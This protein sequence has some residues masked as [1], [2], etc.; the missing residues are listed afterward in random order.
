[1]QRGIEREHVH[2]EPRA[3]T[4][5]EIKLERKVGDRIGRVCIMSKELDFYLAGCWGTS[6]RF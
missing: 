2:L 1:M 4:G 6:E 5:K 3:G